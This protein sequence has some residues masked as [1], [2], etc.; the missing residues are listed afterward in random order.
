MRNRSKM[1]SSREKLFAGA[2][3][4]EARLGAKMRKLDEGRYSQR[5]F[6]WEST[7][8]IFHVRIVTKSLADV[9]E[10][11]HVPRTKHETAAELKR[12]FPD[13]MLAMSGS[14]G[15]GAGCGIVAAEKMKH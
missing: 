10:P 6:L 11:I 8:Q 15:T 5:D 2:S 14:L 7:Q 13:A 12:V 3:S 1:N 9:R 4:P